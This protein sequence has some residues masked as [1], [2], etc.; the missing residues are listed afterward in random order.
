MIKQLR[1]K[2]KKEEYVKPKSLFDFFRRF[3]TKYTRSFARTISLNM[4]A[5]MKHALHMHEY[6]ILGKKRKKLFKKGET[7]EVGVVQSE[8][9][10]RMF[11]W[12]LNNY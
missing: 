1:K 5:S 6:F 7:L 10:N 12:S 3:N 2:S 11:K 8:F 4:W 9:T